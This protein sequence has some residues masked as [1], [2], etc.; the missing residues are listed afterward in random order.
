MDVS[1][2]PIPFV[3]I[4]PTAYVMRMEVLSSVLPELPQYG[5]KEDFQLS[6]TAA[7]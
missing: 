2:K 6:T 4:T 3:S 5:K 1:G 7:L